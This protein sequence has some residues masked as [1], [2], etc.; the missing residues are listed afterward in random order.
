VPVDL[1]PRQNF[2]FQG[3]KVFELNRQ[4][5]ETTTMATNGVTNRKGEDD[6]MIHVTD[7]KMGGN[8]SHVKTG[9]T[10]SPELFEKV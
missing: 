4:C 3:R 7:D 1:K 6:G 10:I 9:M 8:L 2:K 5:L